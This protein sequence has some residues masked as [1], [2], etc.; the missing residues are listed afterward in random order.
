ML[1]KLLKDLD[2]FTIGYKQ[3]QFGRDLEGFIWGRDPGLLWAFGKRIKAKHC[4][5]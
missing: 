4:T 5:I 2:Q 1:G 3:C